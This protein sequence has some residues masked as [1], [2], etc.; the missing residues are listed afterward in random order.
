MKNKESRSNTIRSTKESKKSK[1]DPKDAAKLITGGKVQ[2]TTVSKTRQNG[3][4]KTQIERLKKFYNTTRWL[5]NSA[6][7]TYFGKPAFENYGNGN[8]NPVYGGLFY[9]NYMLSH[10]LN[11]M[12]GTNI[13]DTKQVYSSAM[14]K[15]IRRNEI[16]QPSPPRKVPDE[17]RNT[18]VTF[19]NLGRT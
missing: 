4:S 5:P 16:R 19:H 9:G 6:F 3:P 2:T 15:A 1:I 18:P 12:D 17:I 14:L 10:N 8:T 7:T 11:P 13:P